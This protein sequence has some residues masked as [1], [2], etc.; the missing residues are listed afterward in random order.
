MK[1]LFEKYIK[2]EC[3]KEEIQQIVTYFRNSENLDDFPTIEA[4]S[5]LLDAYPDMDEVTANRI[6]S[7][8]VKSSS[9]NKKVWSYKKMAAVAA[10]FIGVLASGYL[11]Q[12]GFFNALNGVVPES[13]VITLELDNGEVLIISDDDETQVAD[14]QGI[15]IGQQQ[16]N[17]LSYHTTTQIE[18]L[19]Y[20]TLTVPYG[21]RFEL[22]L[23]DGSM[24]YL[25]A[26]TSLRY[27]VKFIKGKTRQIFL[28]G[29]AYFRIS[30]DKAHP[31][32]VN[33]NDVNVEVL[34]TEFNMSSYEEDT[35]IKTVLVEGSVSMYD[36]NTPE[37][38]TL[39]IPGEKGAWNKNKKHI[40]TTQVDI[41][42]HTGWID[43]ELIFR[44]S[45]FSNMARKLE[46][47]YNISIQNDNRELDQKQF[48]A[49]FHVDIESIEEV[50][51]AIS[52]ISPIQY[53]A[54]NNE[55][56]IY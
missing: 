25:N 15:I 51:Q 23:S 50:M 22:S 49:S 33:A 10:I 54:K 30:E 52:A 14:A 48:N 6:Y 43:G 18:T 34:G 11:F 12:N 29:E 56:I 36:K 16:G 19:Q 17:Q 8:I 4:V 31:F 13:E 44:G 28:D 45:S 42:L 32:I 37:N 26:G 9:P 40:T 55:I 39:L 38:K 2:R 20:N 21:K 53:E 46:R 1:E 41:R 3:T 35:E 5:K 47:S 27:P 24:V 7:D